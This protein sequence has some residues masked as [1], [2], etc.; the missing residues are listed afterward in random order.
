MKMHNFV[1]GNESLCGLGSEPGIFSSFFSY[2][3]RLTAELHRS[4]KA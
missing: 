2:F 4:E 1:K 3:D